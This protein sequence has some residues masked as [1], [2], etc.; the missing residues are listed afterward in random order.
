MDTAVREMLHYLATVFSH[1][2]AEP[3]YCALLVSLYTAL[4]K[5]ERS[6]QE[7]HILNCD[8]VELTNELERK[9]AQVA[10]LCE[11]IGELG[12]EVSY[13]KQNIR[14]QLL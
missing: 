10:L 8:K 14:V 5:K 3:S 1:L 7:L 11:I 9:K 6:E 2:P 4:K 12:V 13:L